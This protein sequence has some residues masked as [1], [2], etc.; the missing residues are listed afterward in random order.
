MVEKIDIPS[1]D[2]LCAHVKI[3]GLHICHENNYIFV[4]SV[5]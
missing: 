3:V 2:L 5:L 1:N 4:C